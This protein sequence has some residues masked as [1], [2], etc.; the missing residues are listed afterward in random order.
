MIIGSGGVDV[1]GMAPPSERRLKPGD[2]VTTEL[3][4]AVDGYFRTLLHAGARAGNRL[5][6]KGIRRL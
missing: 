3:T 4:P 5:A 2:L 1:R 6:K